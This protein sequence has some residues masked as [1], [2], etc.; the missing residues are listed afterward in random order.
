M[1]EVR[2][3][4]QPILIPAP[5]PQPGPQPDPQKETPPVKGGASTAIASEQNAI[6]PQTEKV[7]LI[8]AKVGDDI[9]TEFLTAALKRH[10][11]RLDLCRQVM[12]M[13][14]LRTVAP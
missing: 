3:I 6:I 7:A 8:R 5:A 11:C 9:K 2:V 12:R 10:A 13:A 14:Q 1:Y 4:A